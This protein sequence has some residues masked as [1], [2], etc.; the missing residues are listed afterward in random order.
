MDGL[1]P[2]AAAPAQ[3]CCTLRKLFCSVLWLAWCA[4]ATTGCATCKCPSHAQPGQRQRSPMEGGSKDNI[5]SNRGRA[6]G[7][8]YIAHPAVAK[9]DCCPMSR[10]SP[11]RPRHPRRAWSAGSHHADAS[12][13]H[14]RML[15]PA[16]TA[17]ISRTDEGLP[18]GGVNTRQREERTCSG[19]DMD[20]CSCSAANTGIDGSRFSGDADSCQSCPSRRVV[21]TTWFPNPAVQLTCPGWCVVTLSTSVQFRPLSAGDLCALESLACSAR[22]TPCYRQTAGRKLTGCC[23]VRSSSA[24]GHDA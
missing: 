6:A 15:H 11:R 12:A 9:P 21:R 23:V 8:W 13:A 4:G 19:R 1:P 3:A 14:R 10:A 24:L 5:N 17:L 18:S 20:G 16:M 2:L 7:H 22:A